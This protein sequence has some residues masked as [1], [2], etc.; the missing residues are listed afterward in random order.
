MDS[1][2]FSGWATRNNLKCSDGRTIIRDAFKEQHGKTVPL[3]WNHQ[4][5]DPLNVLGHALLENR[6]E[7]VYAY[8]KFNDTELGQEVKKQVMHRDITQLSIY[9]NRL[10]QQ[11]SNVIHGAIREVSLVLAGANP[12]AYI[13]SVIQH[14]E[15]VEGEA[16]IFTG[17][18]F[19]LCHTDVNEEE[20]SKGENKQMAEEV[21]HNEQA[22]S[23]KT[24]QEVFDTLN[25]EQ[26]TVVYALLGEALEQN[27]N[28]GDDEEVK[29]N[30]FTEDNKPQT[31]VICHADQ[32]E[33]IKYAQRSNVG[34]FQRALKDYCEDN[35][36]QHSFDAETL[37][38]LFPEFEDV[39]K[40]A[41]EL[42]EN[43]HEWVN[44]VMKEV[45]KSP[46]SRI[47]TR[48]MDARSKNLRAKGYKKGE[49]KTNFGNLELL[50][51]T[52]DPQTV[53]VKDSLHRDDIVDINDFDVVKYLY[54]VM[55]SKLYEEIAMAIM[56][57]DQRESGE[58]DKISEDHIRSIWNDDELYTIHVDVDYEAAKTELQ[59]TDTNVHFGDNY[60]KAEATI[61][62]SL[63][64]R[65][66]YKGKSVLDC[67]MTPHQLNVM[68]LARD[69]NGRRI[70]SSKADLAKELNV[71]NIY[72]AEQFEGLVRTTKDG[73]KKKLVALFVNLGQYHLGST[74]GGEITNFEQFDIDYNQYK[75][76]IETRVSGA[77]VNI[78]SAIALEEDVTE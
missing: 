47:R 66:Q 9:A 65:E 13:D 17:E 19:E 75:Y 41:P 26:K 12:G 5:N 37:G 53:Y 27:E 49:Q 71:R 23:E 31:Q 72:T 46:I 28:E 44:V 29:H 20:N 15:D 18:D 43:D 77:S 59:G 63:Y 68:L 60:V 6:E 67:F 1:Y 7:G 35:E 2:D 50:D 40:G 33:I 58:T 16:M 69:L 21:K 51:R 45:H 73:K 70:Y 38:K 61:T 4:H 34:S 36:L 10:K 8:C 11:G 14:S 64:A 55:K 74:K 57:G 48:Q 30:A 62:A 56:V 22:S 52:T 24:V 3:V 32:E 39:K 78:K 54:G 25:E 42:V 76:L